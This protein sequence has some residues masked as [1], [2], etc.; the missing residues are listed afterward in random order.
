MN[1]RCAHLAN[2]NFTK[3]DLRGADL[4]AADLTNADFRSADL[5]EV[6]FRGAVL[7]GVNFGATPRDTKAIQRHFAHQPLPPEGCD[8][9]DA[10]LRGANLERVNL[11]Q[12]RLNGA[13]LV[14]AKLSESALSAAELRGADLSGAIFNRTDLTNAD[15]SHANFSGADLRG[16]HLIGTS[17]IAANM[18]GAQ[19]GG[20]VM[21]W[22]SLSGS[23]L[24][25]ARAIETVQ[26][27]GPSII[28]IDT[29][30]RCFREATES[31]TSELRVG[32]TA[33]T[34]F[35]RGVGVPENILELARN[36]AFS[37]G[38]AATFISYCSNDLHF[39]KKLHADLQDEGVRCWYAPETLRV[40]E[41]I[42][43]RIVEA[44]RGH[45]R[46]IV[47]LSEASIRSEWVQF[48]VRTALD[49]ESPKSPT[50]LVPIC[51]D[52]AVERPVPDW[53][54]AIRKIRLI[55]NFLD[56]SDTARY[57][58]ALRRLLEAL[59]NT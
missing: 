56:W 43:T 21:G 37:A 23:K 29:L 6:D 51:I 26:H 36:R 52:G 3:A 31:T 57:R 25:F 15:C 45:A 18:S 1:F 54:N 12:L 32:T 46:V 8:L 11:S 14:N 13:V 34:T 44:I 48:E 28:D 22:T 55:G 40:G 17:L 33:M 35:L 42:R 47:V 10:E 30:E 19:L 27:L 38:R 4:S 59:L 5:R 2:A 41:D 20:S 50:I 7:T 53:V 49:L 39:V 9:S 58:S 24:I 16:A